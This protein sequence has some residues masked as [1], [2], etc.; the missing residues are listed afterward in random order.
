MFKQM[1]LISNFISPV[2][3]LLIKRG[4]F[5]QKSAV[6]WGELW[7]MKTKTKKQ[8][9]FKEFVRKLKALLRR[10]GRWPLP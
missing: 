6:E 3:F 2:S 8:R 7:Q 4:E 5:W 1:S 9:K 10:K